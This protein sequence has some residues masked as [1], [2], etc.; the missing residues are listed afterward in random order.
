M[1]TLRA[2]L[3]LL[4]LPSIASADRVAAL[5]PPAPT[6][7]S[8]TAP[9]A[10]GIGVETNVLW[11]FFPGGISEF[12]LL[13]PITGSGE[14]VLG[15][16]SDYASRVVRDET[17]GKVANYSAKL[18]WRQMLYRGFHVETTL[19][20]G[21]RHEEERPPDNI[22]V[23]GFQIRIW[24]LAGYQHAFSR[25][26]YGNVRGGLGVHVYRSDELAHLEKKLVP[27]ADV[28]LGVRF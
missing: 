2:S 14:L 4:V 27:G 16:Y 22:T 25:H 18:G 17:Y 24:G 13:V 19:N 1:L 20:A 11:P 21:W 15:V 3:A 7:V 6:E 9:P 10:R 28:N 26:F 5:D 23:D 12:R 8:S